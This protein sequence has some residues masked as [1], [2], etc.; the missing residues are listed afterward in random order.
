MPVNIFANL[1]I[2]ANVREEERRGVNLNAFS[3]GGV[4]SPWENMG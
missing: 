3:A 2:I 1:A 4:T